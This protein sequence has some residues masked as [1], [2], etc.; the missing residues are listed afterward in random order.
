MRA[1]CLHLSRLLI[2]ARELRSERRFNDR[3]LR[4]TLLLR[5][6]QRLQGGHRLA[7]ELDEI[8]RRRFGLIF[9]GRTVRGRTCNHR[10]NYNR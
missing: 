10:G 4:D 5:K 7:I 1:F 9:G 3:L 6:P 2:G 8:D